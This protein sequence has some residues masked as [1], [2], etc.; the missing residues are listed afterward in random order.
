MANKPKTG[1]STA[2]RAKQ[3][4]PFAAVRGLNTALRRKEQELGRQAP[5]VLAD[6][7]AA[8]IDAKLRRLQKGS[9]AAV[10]HFVGGQ[11]VQSSGR[12]L[13]LDMVQQA[14]LLSA[15]EPLRI[16]FA[17]IIDIKLEIV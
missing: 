2:E 13:A 5:K 6:G 11:Y 14:L 16:A 1:M 4:M 3:F 7:A 12:V 9:W 8:E 10:T 17:D 15:A